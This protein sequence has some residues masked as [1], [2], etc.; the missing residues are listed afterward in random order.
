[1]EPTSAISAISGVIGIF[2]KLWK[3]YKDHSEKLSSGTEKVESE[4]LLK[5]AKQNLQVAKAQL[6]DALGHVLCRFHFPPGV[7]VRTGEERNNQ[8]QCVECGRKN[9]SD[10]ALIE[11]SQYD[12]FSA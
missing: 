6:A 1:M 12:D 2:D 4:N 5:E 3:M 7:M 11:E 8:W 9:P 10:S